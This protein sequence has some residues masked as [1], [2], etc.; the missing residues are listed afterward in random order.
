MTFGAGAQIVPFDYKNATDLNSAWLKGGVLKNDLD[1]AT[2]TSAAQYAEAQKPLDPIL[3]A[4]SITA[5]ESV[6]K[7]DGVVLDAA[8]GTGGGS[9]AL[10][11]EWGVL[12][13]WDAETEA[14]L[15]SVTALEAKLAAADTWGSADDLLEGRAY[16]FLIAATNF[17]GGTTTTSATVH[18]LA[19]PAPGV[20]FQGAATQTW[21]V[22]P[23]VAQARRRAAEPDLRGREHVVHGAGLRVAR[24]AAGGRDVRPR[25]RPG[26]GGIYRQPRDV[27]PPGGRPGRADD[28]QVPGDRRLRGHHDHQ[29]LATTTAA[30]GSQNLMASISG[31]VEQTVA[32]G[33]TAELDGSESYDPDDNDAEGNMTYAWTV[34]ARAGR[35]E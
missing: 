35:R 14:D 28:L 18:K 8:A 11:Y 1:G 7:C 10:T 33:A 22:R 5:P 12:T 21:S 24:V 25:P 19:S 3:P 30:A 15:T 29:Q 6:G 32:I 23:K 9:R 2:L 34:G 4:I 17:L 26:V 16:E 13:T 27:S 20:Q 31:G